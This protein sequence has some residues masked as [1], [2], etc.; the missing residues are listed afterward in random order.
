[1]I[2][3]CRC[4]PV[5]PLLFIA[6]QLPVAGQPTPWSHFTLAGSGP[7]LN[8]TS[9][10]YDSASNRLMVFGGLGANSSCCVS[11]T[12]ALLS[13]NGSGGTSQWQQLAPSGTLPPSRFAHSAVYDQI[14][15]RMI[16]FGGGV[17][18][19]G[20]F[21]TLFNDVWVLS[22][23]SGVGGTPTWTQLPFTHGYDVSSLEAVAQTMEMARPVMPA[24]LLGLPC[25]CVPAARDAE[26]G[27]PIGV[28]LTGRRFRDDQCLEAAEAV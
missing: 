4:A 6:A 11:D 9:V 17:S 20:V 16:I 14:N 13:A 19:C 12:W 8:S 28:L 1:M 22:N 15:N 5:L 21:C 18:G 25:A 24:N 27:L 10:V 2:R 23:A 7:S 3:F 26:T